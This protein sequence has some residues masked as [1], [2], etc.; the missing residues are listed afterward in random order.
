MDPKLRLFLL[1]PIPWKNI[2]CLIPRSP[3]YHFCLRSLREKL[4]NCFMGIFNIFSFSLLHISL[5]QSL[6]SV[7]SHFL[8]FLLPWK[9]TWASVESPRKGNLPTSLEPWRS[10]P[11]ALLSHLAEP[12][13]SQVQGFPHLC[14]HVCSCLMPEDG[15]GDWELSSPSGCLGHGTEL[16][17][18]KLFI[19][20][21]VP[22]WELWILCSYTDFFSAEIWRDEGRVQG[23]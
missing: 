21:A 15:G 5:N 22:V 9:Q 2:E 13:T 1:F 12:P 20:S 7:P 18:F 8:W 3:K 6:S 23:E 14:C 17:I 10:A 11:A 4:L 19:V 16:C